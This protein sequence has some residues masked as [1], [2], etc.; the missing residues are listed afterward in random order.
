MA[1]ESIPAGFDAAVLR[2]NGN[3][4]SRLSDNWMLPKPEINFL[5]AITK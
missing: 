4:S 5:L 3:R 2:R 1:V